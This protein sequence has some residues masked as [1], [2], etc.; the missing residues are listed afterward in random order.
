[1]PLGKG[2]RPN[3]EAPK[4]TPLTIR[5][6]EMAVLY[7][8]VYADFP[9]VSEL[10]PPQHPAELGVHLHLSAG[11]SIPV[12]GGILVCQISLGQIQTSHGGFHSSQHAPHW[13]VLF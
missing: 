4:D 3:L 10:Y 5:G 1:M 13:K 6:H 11:L 7:E 8:Q 9:P 12:Y 2:L